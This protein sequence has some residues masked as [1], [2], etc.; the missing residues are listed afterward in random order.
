MAEKNFVAQ[1]MISKSIKKLENYFGGEL[2]KRAKFSKEVQF[3]IRGELV[4]EFT[5]KLN[6][7]IDELTFILEK[8]Q[9]EEKI[10]IGYTEGIGNEYIMD[11]VGKL[12]TKNKKLNKFIEII[13]DKKD[14]LNKKLEEGK[15]DFILTFYLNNIE[16]GDKTKRIAIGKVDLDV[17]VQK[18]N[19]KE[20]RDI[21]ILE[22]E[23]IISL[24]D[25]TLQ[26][27]LINEIVEKN[28]LKPKRIIKINDLDMLVELIVSGVGVSVLCKPTIK[29][30][31]DIKALGIDC[32]MELE[33]CL[34]YSK[35]R[36]LSHTEK[37]VINQIKEV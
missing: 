19:E 14:V 16:R 27:E 11:Y 24:K 37:I 36:N 35:N 5:K 8:K 32:G 12:M 7:K 23:A 26:H 1:S 10:R 31:G 20:L 25:G 13:E 9:I 4:Y 30:N 34:E 21:S 2:V 6:L 29:K 18:K 3:T 33:L 15:I 17:Y 28:K 22:R